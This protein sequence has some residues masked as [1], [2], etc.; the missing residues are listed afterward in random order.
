MTVE[1]YA[2]GAAAAWSGDDLE[3][4]GLGDVS[5]SDIK[6]PRLVIEHEEAMFKNTTTGELFPELNVVMLGLVKQRIMWD[7]TV[8]EGDRPQ[9]KAPNNEIGFPQMRTD[10]PERKQFPWS[11]SNFNKDEATINEDGMIMLP[12]ESCIFKDWGKDRE[13]PACSEQYTFPVYYEV[14][15]DTWAPAIMS[16]KSSAIKNAK[17]YAGSFASRKTPMFTAIT[18]L[19]LTPESRSKTRY[20]VPH[21]RQVG[22]SSP[23]MWAEYKATYRSA[24]EF[25]H[26]PPR[27]ADDAPR[28]ER[29]KPASAVAATKLDDD[30]PW[31]SSTS[32]SSTKSAAPPVDDE[33]LPF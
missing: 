12:C 14:A 2:A 17:T 10:I 33:E 22:G 13:R 3:D 19:T 25:L 21:F 16:F 9:C 24:R 5:A 1:P 15:P 4:M 29:S 20:A 7:R 30:D 27:P 28:S 31:A 18:K 11:R 6:M 23:D 8:D 32:T 26:Q